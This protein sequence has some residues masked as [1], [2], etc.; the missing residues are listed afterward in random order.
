[1]APAAAGQ[2]G[3]TRLDLRPSPSLGRQGHRLEENGISSS[4]LKQNLPA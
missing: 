4:T 1:M 3:M 2:R